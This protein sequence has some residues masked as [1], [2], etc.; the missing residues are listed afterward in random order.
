M[1]EYREGQEPPLAS[2]ERFEKAVRYHLSELQHYDTSS[3]GSIGILHEDEVALEQTLKEIV[4]VAD[5][6]TAERVST[7]IRHYQWLVARQNEQRER[8]VKAAVKEFAER[9]VT[10]TLRHD[11]PRPSRAWIRAM[12]AAEMAVIEGKETTND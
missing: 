9:I 5:K 10:K 3:R 1:N 7:A 12:I 6:L 2:N 11:E 4:R 8:E